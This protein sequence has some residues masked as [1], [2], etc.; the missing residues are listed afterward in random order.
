MPTN[1]EIQAALD[2]KSTPPPNIVRPGDVDLGP[3]H[4]L[5][6]DLRNQAFFNANRKDIL[7]AARHGRIV[8][9]LT[10][11]PRQAISQEQKDAAQAAA[12]KSIGTKGKTR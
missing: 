11:A 1:E 3:K 2:A 9:D 5:Q 6:S 12:Q 7:E 8:P 10:P 4:F